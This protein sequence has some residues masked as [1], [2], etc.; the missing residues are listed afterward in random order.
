MQR[1]ASNVSIIGRPD[2]QF[3]C[4][5]RNKILKHEMTRVRC[6]TNH[7]VLEEKKSN[8]YHNE[9]DQYPDQLVTTTG[10]SINYFSTVTYIIIGIP[11]YKI[12][13]YIRTQSI[14]RLFGILFYYLFPFEFL[15]AFFVTST[16]TMYIYIQLSTIDEHVF[17]FERITIIYYHLSD[18][19]RV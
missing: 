19:I 6:D 15:N 10:C 7:R 8:V 2:K 9:N 12:D 13:K 1:V 11:I 16:Y 4:K 17:Q 5:N 14:R 3:Y 18:N